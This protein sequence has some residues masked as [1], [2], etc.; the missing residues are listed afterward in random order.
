MGKGQGEFYIWTAFRG[1][2]GGV[3]LPKLCLPIPH[4]PLALAHTPNSLRHT[5]HRAF[6]LGVPGL[7]RTNTQLLWPLKAHSENLSRDKEPKN[8]GHRMSPG[9]NSFSL[10]LPTSI[11]VPIC[12]HWT[13]ESLHGTI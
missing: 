5:G 13:P 10:T 8:V 2:G 3:F 6:Q 7:N 11:W 9:K 4:I 1:S 12:D